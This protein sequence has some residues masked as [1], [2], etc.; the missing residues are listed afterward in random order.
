[1]AT[2]SGKGH[3]TGSVTNRSQTKGSNGQW[4]KRN[5]Q[6]GQFMNGK[7]DGT[8]HKGVATETDGRRSK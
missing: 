8:K 2:N 3:R 7:A 5:T 1:M 4:I 6:N